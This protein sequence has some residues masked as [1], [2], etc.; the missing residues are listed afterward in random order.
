MQRQTD[1]Q[2]PCQQPARVGETRDGRVV[3]AQ[4]EQHPPA[5]QRERE[6]REHPD[7][8][9]RIR[10]SIVLRQRERQ[11]RRQRERRSPG[12]RARRRTAMNLRRDPATGDEK[13]EHRVDL[14]GIVDEATD[15]VQAIADPPRQAP[16]VVSRCRLRFAR[17]AVAP[18]AGKTGQRDQQCAHEA[19][20]GDR[21]QRHRHIDHPDQQA[22]RGAELQQRAGAALQPTALTQAQP[23]ERRAFEREHARGRLRRQRQRHCQ[24]GETDRQHCVR[25]DQCREVLAALEP[26]RQHRVNHPQAECTQCQRPARAFQ[27]LAL[28]QRGLQREHH[29]RRAEHQAAIEQ[30]ALAGCASPRIQDRYQQIEREEQQQE[31]LG[32]GEVLRAVRQHAPQ[33][34][35]R[36][37]EHEPEHVQHPPR[38][39]PR[40]REDRR[41]QHRVVAEQGDVAALPRR[42]PDRRE[43]TG[44][45]AQQRQRDRVLLHRQHAGAGDQH[46]AQRE[47]R[48]HR[49]QHVKLERG[50][51]HQQQHADRP[52]LQAQAEAALVL[53]LAPAEHQPGQRRQRDS[54]QPQLDRERHPALVAGVLEQRRDAGEQ[55]QHADLDRHVAFA[56]PATQR[57]RSQRQRIR[58]RS[59]WRRPRSVVPLRYRATGCGRDRRGRRYRR[60]Q[61]LVSKRPGD[62][63]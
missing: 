60:R 26:P 15:L 46:D 24:R 14:R 29:Q 52:A 38:P 62:G 31:R 50:E 8:S 54:G 49:N 10:V 42:Q 56:E 7:A 18:G 4:G 19:G 36:K 45:D 25:G 44:E 1:H 9:E 61:R 58:L 11:R 12:Q 2:R 28:Q 33:R 47:R 57:A 55:H 53:A 27:R 21:L 43:E 5:G 34:A 23:H 35:D 40:D 59:R 30:V 37:C 41:V 17:I 48:A 16:Q 3:L 39:P 32:G 20:V 6:P 63:R 51:H 13:R 22:H